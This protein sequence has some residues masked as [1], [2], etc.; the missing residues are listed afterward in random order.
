MWKSLSSLDYTLITV[1]YEKCN[2]FNRLTKQHEEM[3]WQG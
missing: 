3:E 1:I 2:D